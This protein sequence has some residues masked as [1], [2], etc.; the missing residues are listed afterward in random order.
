[1]ELSTIKEQALE[2][3]L[4]EVTQPHD[5]TIDIIHNFLCEQEDDE[6]FAGILVE[7]K[8]IKDALNFLV[9]EAKKQQ[10]FRITD[11]EGFKIIKQY[12]LGTETKVASVGKVSNGPVQS[13]KQ[14]PD[15]PDVK[16]TKNTT[17][18]KSESVSNLSIFD[19]MDESQ[20][21]PEGGE[22]ENEE[23]ETDEADD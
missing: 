14:Q 20:D 5:E 23:D 15:K 18:K 13:S 4:V 12:F 8:T 6:L 1:M 19:F 17:K 16:A 21:V 11:S 3:M 2:K 9:G 22:I 10:R 7:G